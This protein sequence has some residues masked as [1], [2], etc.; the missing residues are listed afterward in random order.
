MKKI[1][2]WNVNGLR[3]CAEKGFFDFFSDADAD[4]FCVQETKMHQSQANFSFSGY[5]QF[6]NSADK[7][8]YSGTL[9]LSKE[10]PLRFIYGIDRQYNDEGRVITLEFNDYYLVTV[11]SPN[12]RPELMRIDYRMQFEDD[13]RMYLIRL[14]YEKPVVLCGDM[15]VAHNEIDLKNPKNN[16]G[17]PGFSYEERSCFSALLNSGFVD[18]FRYL[19]PDMRDAYTWWSYRANARA[20]NVGWRIDY[21]LVSDSIKS[22]IHDSVIYRDVFGSDHC[23]IGLFIDLKS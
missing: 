6:W 4:V 18:T 23:P 20:N 9:I 10:E 12:S 1:I 15:N 5:H 7:K 13:L 2:S 17:N 21:F 8:G 3:A 22:K 19:Y 16:I 11:Y 14:A